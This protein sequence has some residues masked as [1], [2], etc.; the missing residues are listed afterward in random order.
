MP[1]ILVVLSYP[2]EASGKRCVS[3]RFMMTLDQLVEVV[4]RRLLLGLASKLKAIFNFV[5]EAKRT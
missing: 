1:P 3:R 5:R 2:E 4:A